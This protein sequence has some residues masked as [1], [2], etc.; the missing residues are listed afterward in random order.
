MNSKT[1]EEKNEKGKS[2]VDVLLLLVVNH[3]LLTNIDFIVLRGEDDYYNI[4][5]YLVFFL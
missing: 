1:Y 4:H 2:Y 3:Y 5:V